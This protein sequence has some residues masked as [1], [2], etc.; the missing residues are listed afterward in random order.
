MSERREIDFEKLADWAEGR[1]DEEEARDVEQRLAAADE[2]T[3]AE[4]EW[5]R[6]F[7]RESEDLVIDAPPSEVREELIRRFENR[8]ES[9]Q[10]PGLI[11]RLVARLS[12]EG[13]LQPAFG[14][15][16]A[17][18]PGDQRQLV[19]TTEAADV[20]LNIRPRPHN[21]HLDLDGQIF[22][23]DDA[24]PASF[25]VQLLSGAAEVGITSTDEL[26]EFAFEGIMPDTYQ[27][28]VSG[29]RVEILISPVEL[30]A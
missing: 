14:V 21:G 26:G 27:I 1:L 11:E 4:A 10:R 7:A 17:G 12:F 5:L 25:S 22:P 13:G 3:R 23:S 16:S 29:E 9:Q 2:E 6:A 30:G 20:A 24:D 18:T 28:L 8:A 15:R 19:Y